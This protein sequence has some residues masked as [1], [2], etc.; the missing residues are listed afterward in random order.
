MVA[1]I[2]TRDRASASSTTGQ[3]GEASEKNQ[4]LPVLSVSKDLIMLRLPG[5]LHVQREG[6]V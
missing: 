3:K 6:E 4:S 1:D 2:R 5:G